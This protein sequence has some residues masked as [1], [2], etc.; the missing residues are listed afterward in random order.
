MKIFDGKIHLEKYLLRKAFNESNLLPDVVLWRRKCAFSD[1]V[2]DKE[3]S[4][5]RVIKSFVDHKISDVEFE[6][7]DPSARELIGYAE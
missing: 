1:G 4:W 5:H 2:S 6:T 3:N 7:K